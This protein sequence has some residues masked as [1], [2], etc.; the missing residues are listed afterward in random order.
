M[1]RTTSIRRDFHLVWIAVLIMT[2]CSSPPSELV[3]AAR[4]AEQVALQDGGREYAPDAMS[5]VAQTRTALEVELAAQDERWAV[6]RSYK[7][8]EELAEQYRVAGERAAVQTANARASARLAAETLIADGQAL[9][10]ET[11]ALLA[12]A[13]AGKGSAADLAAMRGDLDVAQTGL[14]AARSLLDSEQ[15]LEAQSSAAAAREIIDRVK[16]AVD[17]ARMARSS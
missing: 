14:D 9:L 11:R 10:G 8:A 13:P 2:A 5:E 3:T 15:Y 7:Q 4:D 17:I 6:R 12:G 1:K 16:A